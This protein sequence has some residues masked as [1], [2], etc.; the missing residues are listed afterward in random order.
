MTVQ[1]ESRNRCPACRSAESDAIWPA[2]DRA[3]HIERCRS[4][5]LV[6]T[7]PQLSAHEIV[8]YYD[9]R[10]YG[11]GN[12]RFG[13]VL[14][15]VVSWCRRRRADKI[16][17][18]VSSGRVLDVGCGRGHILNCLRQRG[19]NVQ[20]VEMNENAVRHAR[21]A[22]GLDV[23]VE[24]FDPDRFPSEH[25]DAIILWHVLEHLPNVETVLPG[26]ARMLRLGGLL[27]LSVPNFASWQSRISRAHWFHLDLP[28]HYSH[29]SKDWLV[30]ALARHQLHVV[31]VNHFAFE[32]NPFG[33]IQ[34][35]LNCC[36]VPHNLLYDMLK[37][38]SAR[39]IRSP[40]REHPWGSVASLIGLGLLLGPACGMLLVEA[41]FQRGATIDVFA[42]KSPP[43]ST[44]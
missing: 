36:H 17:R 40:L 18:F 41:A 4:C 23:R 31:E 15:S 29:F 32:Q 27:A 5:R 11:A 19:W 10:Y 24:C 34:S 16:C 37:S 21:D 6:F 26:L 22:L 13:P 28:R 39:T 25:F 20:G 38:R 3:F 33:W 30:A 9:E 1:R 12:V 2:A 7:V 43:S 44:R 42:I 14:E 8:A 35:L